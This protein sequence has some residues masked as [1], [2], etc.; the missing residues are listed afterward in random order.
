MTHKVSVPQKIDEETVFHLET[1]SY[2]VVQQIDGQ[3][4]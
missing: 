2:Q 3:A 1:L 4:R